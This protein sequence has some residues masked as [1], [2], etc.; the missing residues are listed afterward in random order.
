MVFYDVFGLYDLFLMQRYELFS[1]CA[2]HRWLLS[3]IYCENAVKKNLI[4]PDGVC[5]IRN[6]C[7]R[8]FYQVHLSCNVKVPVFPTY[9][10]VSSGREAA[11]ILHA[12]TRLL[13]NAP[14]GRR[15]WWLNLVF[16][17]R[18]FSCTDVQRCS[19][20]SRRRLEVPP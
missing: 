13:R 10:F 19:I 12:R 5:A 3:V 2:R 18:A 6:D 1:R 17:L 16:L 4:I 8:A 14:Y 11:E 20:R 7:I 9:G 15:W